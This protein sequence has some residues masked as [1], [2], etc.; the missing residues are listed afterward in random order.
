LRLLLLL[1][2][3]LLVG[4]SMRSAVLVLVF[5]DPHEAL[6]LVS[7]GDRS[8]PVHDVVQDRARGE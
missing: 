4:S 1:L 3:L 7:I 8:A 5:S 2:L 6:L